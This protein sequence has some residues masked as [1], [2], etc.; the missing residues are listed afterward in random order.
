MCARVCLV[1]IRNLSYI[2]QLPKYLAAFCGEM[3]IIYWNRYSKQ[4]TCPAHC[5]YS[6][7]YPLKDDDST[8][9]KIIGYLKFR[10]FAIKALKANNYDYIIVLPTQTGILLYD[11]LVVH[12]RGK[13]LLAIQDYT[14][15]YKFIFKHLMSYLVKNA[16]IVTITSPAFRNFLPTGKYVIDHNYE[17]FDKKIIIEYRAKKRVIDL[18]RP[19]VISCVGGIRFYDSFSRLIQV[20]ANDKRFILRFDGVGAEKLLPVCEKIGA[21]NVVLNGGFNRRETARINAEGDIANNYFGNNSPFLNYALSN[22][23]YNAAQLGMPII[24]CKNTYTETITKKYG[25][26]YSLD[27]NDLLCKNKLYDWYI[28]LNMDDLYAGCDAFI[29]QAKQDDVTLHRILS[30][31]L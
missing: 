16:K 30:S 31:W 22:R 5:L 19:I 14:A 4:E 7:N 20:F 1:S 13:Y 15:E 25:F 23:L 2:T 6:Y 11:Y 21:R 9:K 24:V 18:T 17:P 3:D 26:G 28:Q 10:R 29:E 8:I 12:M 27:L